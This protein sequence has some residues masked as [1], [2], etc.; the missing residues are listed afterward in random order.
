MS[1]LRFHRAKKALYAAFSNRSSPVK[2]LNVPN[3]RM[4]EPAPAVPV[5][6]E[7]RDSKL[8]EYAHVS[9]DSPFGTP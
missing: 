2:R 5:D 6:D 4:S 3:S 1:D 9:I 8:T 7:M